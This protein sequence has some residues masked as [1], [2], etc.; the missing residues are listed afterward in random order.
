MKLRHTIQTSG[1][2]PI[3]AATLDGC[4]YHIGPDGTVDVP[5]WLVPDL[6]SRGFVRVDG[7]TE[8]I[9]TRAEL[10]ATNDPGELASFLEASPLITWTA[11]PTTIPRSYARSERLRRS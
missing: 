11:S 9:D 5:R 6:E 10:T 8:P 4:A 2:V 7:S 1:K 3:I